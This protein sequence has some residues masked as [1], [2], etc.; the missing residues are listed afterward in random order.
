MELVE[1]DV[2][3]TEAAEAAVAGGADVRGAAVEAAQRVVVRV[4]H[5]A[6]LGGEHHLLAPPA[7]GAPD[8]LLVG[9]R[10]VHVRRVEERHAEVEGPVDGGDRLGLVGGSVE[11]AHAHAAEPDRGHL[12]AGEPACVHAHSSAQGFLNR[13]GRFSRKALRPSSASSVP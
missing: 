7:D 9:I 11:L 10:P 2:V 3:D 12:E 13:G 6:A 8:E 1:V 5:D 4:A